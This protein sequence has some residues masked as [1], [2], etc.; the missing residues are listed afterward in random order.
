[1]GRFVGVVSG[2][3][4]TVGPAV[5]AGCGAD[6]TVAAGV[7]VGVGGVPDEQ[8]ITANPRIAVVVAQ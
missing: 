3:G 6:S 4:G 7:S 5:A 8:D 2:V 1:M